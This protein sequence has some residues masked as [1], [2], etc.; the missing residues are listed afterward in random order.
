[1]VPA[2]KSKPRNGEGRT[3]INDSF[4]YTK[5]KVYGLQPTHQKGQMERVLELSYETHWVLF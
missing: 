5:Q 3:H 2:L 4:N 1:M